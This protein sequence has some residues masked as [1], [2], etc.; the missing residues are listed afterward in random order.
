MLIDFS[1]IK[2]FKILIYFV[3]Y[4]LEDKLIDN[5]QNS[6][7]EKYSDILSISNEISQTK[8][9]LIYTFIKWV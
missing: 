8:D 2:W 7:E 3:F 1:A 5:A 6:H 9:I 4:K